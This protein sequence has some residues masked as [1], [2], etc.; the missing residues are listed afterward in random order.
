MCPPTGVTNIMKIQ[1]FDKIYRL[2]KVLKK[3]SLTA[4]NRCPVRKSFKYEVSNREST[5]LRSM[6]PFQERMSEMSNK[7]HNLILTSLEIP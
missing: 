5:K 2:E 3:S 7:Q 6:L 1:K 4:T